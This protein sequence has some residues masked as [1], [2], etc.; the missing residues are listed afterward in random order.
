MGLRVEVDELH[1]A[2]GQIAAAGSGPSG[3]AGTVVGAAAADAVSA[4]IAAGLSTRLQTI[5]AHSARAAQISA[6]SAAVLHA[7]ATTYR[8]QEDLNAEALKA[9]GGTPGLAAPAPVA[10]PGVSTPVPVAPV[11]APAGVTPT[12]GKMI[13]ALIHGGPGTGAL[14]AA[15]DA[16]R[17]HAGQLRDVSVELR[18]A[19][20]RLST[21]QSPA[22]EAAAARL[23]LLA[24]WYDTHAEHCAA[25]AQECQ[26]QADTF[27]RTRANTPT[28]EK[29]ADLEQRLRAATA[30][31]AAARGAYAPVITQLQ[32]ELARTHGQAQAAYASYGRGIAASTDAPLAPP[33]TVKPLDNPTAP[34]HPDPPAPPNPPAGDRHIAPST[35]LGSMMLPPPTDAPTPAAPD[36]T[37]QWVDGIAGGRGVAPSTDV[38]GGRGMAPSTDVPGGGGAAPPSDIGSMMLPPPT[39]AA[40]PIPSATQKWLDDMTSALAARPPDDPIAVEARRMAWLALNQPKTCDSWEWTSTVGG[41]GVSLLGTGATAVAVPAGP[42]DWALLAASVGGVGVSYENLLKC[43]S[44]AGAARVWRGPGTPIG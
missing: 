4:T 41:L 23:N 17:V 10:A 9:D 18:A 38:P 32:T 33:D 25:T 43:I 19:R 16:A 37:K 26:A 11:S 34:A 8:A 2:G 44:Q 21:W 39:A 20:N 13:A 27:S 36:P 29:F 30:A 5:G 12:D 3:L 1:T 35:D 7:N 28:P 42:A 40:P 14:I 31:N 6:M 22:G 15:A 24:S